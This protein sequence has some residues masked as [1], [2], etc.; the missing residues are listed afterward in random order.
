MN[1]PLVEE[2]LMP[3]VSAADDA[4]LAALSRIAFPPEMLEGVVFPKSAPPWPVEWPAEKAARVFIVRHKGRI[5]SSCCFLPRRIQTCAGPLD[6]LGLAGVKTLPEFRMRGYG[7][8]V[9][10]AAFQYVDNGAFCASLFQTRVPGF[11]EKLGCRRVGNAF[12]NRFGEEPSGMPWWDPVRMVYP[13]A[14][15]WPEGSVD[16]LGPAW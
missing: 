16:L 13:A 14:R 6:V 9:V 4:E 5:A 11:Y 3:E 10:R 15:A 8:A 7:A 2:F 1:T 12:T